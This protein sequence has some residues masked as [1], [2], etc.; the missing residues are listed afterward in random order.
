MGDQITILHWEGC[1]QVSSLKS[2]TPEFTRHGK[3]APQMAH[4]T[5]NQHHLPGCAC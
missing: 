5:F 4:L 3:Q 1:V 2:P